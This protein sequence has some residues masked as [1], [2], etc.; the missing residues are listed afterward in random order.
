MAESLDQNQLESHGHSRVEEL[1]KTFKCKNCAAMLEFVPG[2]GAQ[3]CPYCG[4][5]HPIP[6]QDSLP[7]APPAVL[8]HSCESKR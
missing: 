7:S 1:H 4:H 8:V 2:A 5:E 6:Q 3:K